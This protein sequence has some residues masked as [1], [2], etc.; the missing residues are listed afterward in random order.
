MA[1]YNQA[2][3]IGTVTTEPQHH[4]EGRDA[5]CRF[6]VD[7][8]SGWGDRKSTVNVGCIVEGKT[9]QFISRYIKTGDTILVSGA[10]IK[11]APSGGVYFCCGFKGDV[12]K[13]G[14]SR[15]GQGGGERAQA[16]GGSGCADEH[17]K[18]NRPAAPQDRD[19]DD[20]LPF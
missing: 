16:G 7:I 2:N 12:T 8:E 5:K 15:R 18:Q 1:Q 20:E 19:A 10:E 11:Q 4:G 6:H 14:S 13:V 17:H 3:F 9:C